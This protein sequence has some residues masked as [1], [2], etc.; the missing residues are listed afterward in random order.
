MVLSISISID[1]D[2]FVIYE[3]SFLAKSSLETTS[4]QASP[5]AARGT[6]QFSDASSTGTVAR[7]ALTGQ[8]CVF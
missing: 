7:Q 5:R 4:S 8:V 1:D 3:C 2:H 6:H